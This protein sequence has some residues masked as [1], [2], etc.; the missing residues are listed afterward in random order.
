MEGV[1]VMVVTVVVVLV[2]MDAGEVAVVGR[3][4]TDI[5]INPF[6]DYTWISFLSLRY[7]IFNFPTGIG[8]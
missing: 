6:S 7:L 4:F 8:I 3:E 2:L 1:V 5:G